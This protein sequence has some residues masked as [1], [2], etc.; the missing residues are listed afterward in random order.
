MHRYTDSYVSTRPDSNAF[1]G[2]LSFVIHLSN[3]TR[4]GCANFSMINN[5][6]VPSA[7]TA[8]PRPT[9]AGY[10]TTNPSGT[11]VRPSTTLPQV[12][13]NSAAK[14]GGTGAML[15]VAAALVL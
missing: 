3:K 11:P 6:V 5:N 4:I 15:A 10:N 1:F 9:G 2:N 12:T 13:G 14:L 7:S 8:L